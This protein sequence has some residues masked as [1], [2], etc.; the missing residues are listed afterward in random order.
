MNPIKIVR[1]EKEC[2][3]I[4]LHSH[5]GNGPIATKS[6][7]REMRSHFHPV[8]RIQKTV[9]TGGNTNVSEMVG[10]RG[11]LDVWHVRGGSN[12]G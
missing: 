10:M 1:K 5:F 6:R 2:H 11:W 8:A 7:T 9:K 4:N 3:K 12:H